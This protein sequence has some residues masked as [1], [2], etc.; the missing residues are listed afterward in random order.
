MARDITERKR[1]EEA[2]QESEERLRSM[3]NRPATRSFLM[4][5]QGRVALWNS[6]AE[7]TF[8]YTAEEMLGQPVS[9]IIPQ[10]F[11]EAHQ[12]GVERVAATG[13]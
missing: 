6:G 13:R 8:G 7:R 2:L 5:T 3:F 10:R 9:R 1:A 12:R 4:D 11:H